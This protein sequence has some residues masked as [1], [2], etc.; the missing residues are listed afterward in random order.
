MT[1]TSATSA[2]TGTDLLG[3]I[4]NIIGSQG[5]DTMTVNGGVNILDGQGGNDTLNAG[6]GT[7]TVSGGDGADTLIGGTGND[8]LNGGTGNDTFTYT[9][10]DGADTVDGGTGFDTLNITGTTGND[11]LDVVYTG[12]ALTTVEGGTVTGVE[13]VTANLLDQLV[14][15]SDVLTYA[16]TSANVTVNLAGGSASGFASIAAIENV[17]GGSGNDTLTGS[18]G[19]NTL[20]GGAGNDTL[21]GNGGTDTLVGGAG[22]DLYITDGGDTLTEAANSGT[23]TVQS[24][25]SFTLAANFENLTFTGAAN[26]NGTGNGVANIVTGNNGNNTLLG[27]G[28]GDTL[29]GGLG[30]DTLNGGAGTDTL[31]GGLG[32]DTFVF[33]TAAEAGN[34]AARDVITDFQG[35]GAAGGDVIDVSGIDANTGVAADQAFTFIGTAAFTAA[36]QFHYVQDA[37]NNLTILEGNVNVGLGADFQ[38]A[39][40]GLHTVAAGDFTL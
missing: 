40:T 4:E 16:G 9:M 23:D 2:D 19:A 6:G 36:G 27:L 37:I 18:A 26:L 10:G 21:D 17:T 33:A 32:D 29:S 31:T 15:G 5:N 7:D 39:L 12:T 13:A 11:T 8:L 28:G 22:D 38:I 25:V 35:A 14:G 1:A 30:N 3:G 24:A 34:G 20:T